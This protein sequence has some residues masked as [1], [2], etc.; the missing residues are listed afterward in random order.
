MLRSARPSPG[1]QPP[2]VPTGGL[3]PTQPLSR[4]R[5]HT[6]GKGPENPARRS[7]EPQFQCVAAAGRGQCGPGKFDRTQRRLWDQVLDLKRPQTRE[8]TSEAQNKARPA[9]PRILIAPLWIQMRVNAIDTLFV[10]NCIYKA[11]V[12]IEEKPENRATGRRTSF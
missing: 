11:S 4:T 5:T 8:E 7:W 12:I 2:A 3:S 10:L 1:P 6:R 9:A